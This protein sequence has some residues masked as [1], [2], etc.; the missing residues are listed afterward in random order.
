MAD[1]FQ[2]RQ[3]CIPATARRV[4]TRGLAAGMVASARIGGTVALADITTGDGTTLQGYKPS[5][6]VSTDTNIDT[7]KVEDLAP[8]I[9][10]RI[11]EAVK[12]ALPILAVLSVVVIIYNAVRNMF[13]PDMDPKEARAMG[14]KPKRPMGQVLKDVFMMFFWIMFAWI[15]VELIIWGVTRLEVVA[16]S[17][18]TGGGAAATAASGQ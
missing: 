16:S 7:T 6:M 14:K 1:R 8:A 17:S 11:V 15:I 18:L 10:S 12:M 2:G 5:D 13:L 3:A 9:A 4:I